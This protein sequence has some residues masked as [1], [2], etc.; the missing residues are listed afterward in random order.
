MITDQEIKYIEKLLS[1]FF[2]GTTTTADE[3]E[4]YR[5][6]R[7]T[8]IP[9]HLKPYQSVFD[10]FEIGLKE[11]CSTLKK[12]RYLTERPKK[13]RW[14]MWAGIAASLLLFVSVGIQTHAG[15][16]EFNPY[17]GSYIIRNGVRIDDPETIKPE[18]EIVMARVRNQQQEI[19]LVFR[20]VSDGEQ[21]KKQIEEA[22]I[23]Q[24]NEILDQFEDE[25]VRR[26]IKEIMNITPIN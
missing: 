14:I 4:L 20:R 9:D 22:V 21:D 3:K 23:S 10:Y 13:K 2:D 25:N 17:E 18:L 19:E 12:E 11:E 5:F 24:Q 16:K 26:K 6:F 8:D 7:R 1:A 15:H